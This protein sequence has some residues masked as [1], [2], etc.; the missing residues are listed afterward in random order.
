MGRAMGAMVM[1]LV[2]AMALHAPREVEGEVDNVAFQWTE[3]LNTFICNEPAA[4]LTASIGPQLHLAQWHALL[5]LRATGGCTTEEAVVAYA[6]FKIM[7][8]YFSWTQTLDL[9]LGPLLDQ[10]LQV[11]N[12]TGPQERLAQRLGEAVA[13]SLI[14]KRSPSGQF[15]LGKVKKA[16]IAAKHPPPP[17]VYRFSNDTPAGRAAAEFFFTVLPTYQPFVIPH[18]VNF[19]KQYFPDK[20]KPPPIPSKEWDANWEGLKDIGR[21]GF[22]GRTAEMNLT[23]NLIGCPR[24]G[25]SKCSFEMRATTAAKSSLPN[26][27]SLYDSVLL[28]AKISVAAFDAGIAQA[29]FKYGL[30]FWRPT[31]AYRAGDSHHAPIPDWTPFHPTPLEPEYPSGTVTIVSAAAV[32][33]QTFFGKGK[34]VA[35]SIEGGG[36]FACDGFVGD[37]VPTR[38]YPSLEAFVHEAQLSRMY[39]GA[40]F[41]KAV[42]D[43]YILGNAV[44]A[45]VEK[46]WGETAPSGVL[47]DQ[48]FL[49]LVYTVPAKTGDFTPVHY[50]IPLAHAA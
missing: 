39:S 9:Y 49:D 18:P 33:L 12:L 15:T 32:P 11:M 14:Q 46:H 26:T 7:G 17:G 21:L 28:L 6:S 45:Y 27:T 40:H 30:W 41:Q 24:V 47:P 38:N 44:G 23:A 19:V 1:L 35:F 29:T 36:T 16:L 3:L 42:D 20:I 43:A 34:K 2:V 4:P 8:H 31:Q 5:A 37:P 48:T 22:P 10:Q 25:N 13:V 50:D